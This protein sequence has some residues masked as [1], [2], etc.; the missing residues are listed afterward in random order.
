MIIRNKADTGKEGTNLL[1]CGKTSPCFRVPRVK[2]R[3]LPKHLVISI[4]D[5]DEV[6]N[7]TDFTCVPLS[8]AIPRLR[9]IHQ[10]FSHDLLESLLVSRGKIGVYSQN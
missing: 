1:R 7:V 4:Y 2:L 3:A 9:T 6:S 10:H 5:E 8:F